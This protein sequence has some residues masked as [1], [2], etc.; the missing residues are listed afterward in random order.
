[1]QTPATT[2]RRLRWG[3]GTLPWYY[4]IMINKV[5]ILFRVLLKAPFPINLLVQPQPHPKIRAEIY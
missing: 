1:M 3:K 2:L 5:N 4:W